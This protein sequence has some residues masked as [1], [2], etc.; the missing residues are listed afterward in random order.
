MSSSAAR[1]QNERSFNVSRPYRSVE[2]RAAL[3][4][5]FNLPAW[6]RHQ[7]SERQS[8]CETPATPQLI[9][10]SAR[11]GA[12]SMR[13]GTAWICILRDAENYQY[14]TLL[15]TA[16]SPD[17]KSSRRAAARMIEYVSIHVSSAFR[18]RSLLIPNSFAA[19]CQSGSSLAR[20]LARS[21]A[22]PLAIVRSQRARSLVRP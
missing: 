12:R 19:F 7:P 21:P 20:S 5:A 2:Y 3:L 10:I 9:D 15:R 11:R 14:L 13:G 16:T 17:R 1:F 4:A 6:L 8:L 18:P 22:R